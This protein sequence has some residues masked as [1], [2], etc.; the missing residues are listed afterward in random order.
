MRNIT[1]K[2]AERWLERIRETDPGV[3]KDLGRCLRKYDQT[4]D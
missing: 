3:Y 1:V 4:S 2:Q